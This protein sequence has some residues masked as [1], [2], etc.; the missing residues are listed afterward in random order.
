M[1]EMPSP[2]ETQPGVLRLLEPPDADAAALRRLLVAGRY[3]KPFV[4]EA[5]GTR[6]L[7][8]VPDQV[9][10]AMRLAAPEALS[11]R[12]TR[13]MM[14]FLLF[15]PRPRE[16]LMLG[17]GG[18][19]LAKFC[20]RYLPRTR[21]SVVENNPW[22]AAWR[23]QFVV[24][25]DGPRFQVHLADASEYVARCDSQPDAILVDAFD[26]S[27]Y[28]ASIASR[29]F[30]ALAREALARDGVLVANLVGE[31]AERLEHI[32]AVRGAFGDASLLLPVP[33]DGNDLLFAFRNPSFS[34]RW[35]SVDK[36]ARELK[37]A[38]GLDLPRLARRLERSQKLGYLRRA[39]MEAGAL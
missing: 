26:R 19:S 10:S 20:F 1:F 6:A 7:H 24:P 28:A 21:V 25:A 22:V 29:G 37:A 2:F 30:Y 34:P 3:G 11:F 17:L 4:I 8:F 39:L 27:G 32:A 31:R 36:V 5:D 14:G 15:V 33:G 9:Q 13:E 23:E 16:V 38:L 12:Y 35:R 18:G